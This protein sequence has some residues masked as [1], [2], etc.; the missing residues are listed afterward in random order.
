M[1]NGKIIIQQIKVH[2]TVHNSLFGGKNINF[3]VG[4]CTSRRIFAFEERKR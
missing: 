3:P 2:F 1:F 4:G